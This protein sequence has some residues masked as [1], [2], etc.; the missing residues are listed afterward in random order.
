MKKIATI[1]FHWATNY[2]AVLQ[3]YA[4]QKA[5]DRLGYE[6]EIIDYVPA[7]TDMLQKIS[8]VIKRDVEFFKKE[9]RIK[10][11]RKNELAVSKK[12]YKTN[13]S[14]FACADEYSAIVAGS[15]Q[16]WNPSFTMTAEGRPTL[17]Y[18][19]NF[20][21]SAK[22]VSYAASF[23]VTALC[24]DMQ[25]VIL[26]ELE[27]FSSIS[28]REQTGKNMLASMGISSTV[29]LDPTLLLK[30][31]DYELLCD[32]AKRVDKNRLAWYVKGRLF[33]LKTIFERNFYV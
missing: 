21:G 17:S 23:G 3:S 18:Y 30:K 24:E 6:N 15:D 32:K 13:K 31:K 19:L 8:K 26:P 7:R 29:V 16:I 4:L 33:F 9:R 14:L 27:K 2:G 11:F 5:I 1:T 25:K 22:R 28:V 12:R 20:A 10:K